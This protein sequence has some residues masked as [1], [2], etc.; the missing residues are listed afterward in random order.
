M[1]IQA[2]R[3][4]SD[5]LPADTPYWQYIEDNARRLFSAYGYGE[6]RFPIVEKTELFARSIGEVTDIVEKEMYVFTDRSGES[7]SLRP[8]GTAGCVR[9][10]IQH[11]LLRNQVQRLWYMGPM[12]RHERPQKGRYRQFHQIGVEAFGIP[13]PTIDAEML[14]MTARL[15]RALGVSGL[16]LELNALCAGTSRDIY[17]DKLV[18]YFSAQLD[19]LDEDSRRRLH[20]NPLRILDSKNPDLWPVIE[21]APRISD[22]LDGESKA[23][24][25]TLQS[26][27]DA[28]KIDYVVNPYLVRGLDYYTGTVFEW[29]TS[30]LGAQAAVCAGGRFDTLVSQM[31]ERATPAVGYAIGLERLVELLKEDTLLKSDGINIPAVTPHAYLVAVGGEAGRNGHSLAEELRDRFPML[32][33]IVDTHAGSFKAKLKRADRSAARIALIL[34]EDEVATRRVGVKYLREQVPQRT[35]ARSELDDYLDILLAD[36]K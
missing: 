9:A 32:R 2:I 16:R 6:I 29:T 10:G 25:E 23:H 5:I 22:F 4:M 17:R 1:T 31:G 28:V 26:I 24:F 14:I 21:N 35:L 18:D 3:G 33:L 13:D 30:R 27:L 11:R 7:L 15:W 8:E 20:T 12:F 19:R 34:G 36:M